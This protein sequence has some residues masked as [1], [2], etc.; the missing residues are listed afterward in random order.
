MLYVKEA[1][2][3]DKHFCVFYKLTKDDKYIRQLEDY[4]IMD[5]A[6]VNGQKV[7]YTKIRKDLRNQLELL[8]EKDHQPPISW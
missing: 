3:E 1:T 5:W 8:I 2:V 6:E 4:G 7:L